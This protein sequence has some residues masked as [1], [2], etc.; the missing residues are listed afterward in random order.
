MQRTVGKYLID[1]AKEINIDNFFKRAVIIYEPSYVYIHAGELSFPVAKTL[2]YSASEE[3][4]RKAL[5]VLIMNR[6]YELN[7]LKSIL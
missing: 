7:E 1:V 3:E 6:E 5:K 4:I 2:R